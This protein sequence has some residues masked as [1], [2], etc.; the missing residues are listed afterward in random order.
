MRLRIDLTEVP[1]CSKCKTSKVVIS[2]HHM[3]YDSY[4]GIYNRRIA[5]DYDKFL[6]CTPLCDEC[7]MEIHWIYIPI[8]KDWKVWTFAGVAVLRA[9]LIEVCLAWLNGVHP[10]HKPISAEFRAK[11]QM[12][13][14]VPQAA[15][16]AR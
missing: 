14:Q 4:L 6:D 10:L 5:R 12:G 9:K 16:P 15:R 13:N 1:H 7:H 3:G 8:V 11:W 2:R